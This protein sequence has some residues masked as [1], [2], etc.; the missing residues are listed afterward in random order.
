[1]ISKSSKIARDEQL[2]ISHTKVTKAYISNCGHWSRHVWQEMFD[3]SGLAIFELSQLIT[4][5]K[6]P[7]AGGA[8]SKSTKIARGENPYVSRSKAYISAAIGN[9]ADTAGFAA[10]EPSC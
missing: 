9:V 6:V 5:S 3:T 4:C 7:P 8:I 1:M 10:I 2:Y